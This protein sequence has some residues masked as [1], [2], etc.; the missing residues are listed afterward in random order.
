[1]KIIYLSFTFHDM[2]ID[3][4]VF[5]SLNNLYFHTVKSIHY[6]VWAIAKLNS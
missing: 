2:Q 6:F 4:F 1:M 5:L 3:S